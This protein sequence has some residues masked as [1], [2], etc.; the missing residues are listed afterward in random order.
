MYN[1]V[2]LSVVILLFV[3]YTCLISVFTILILE[4]P[5][6]VAGMLK[7][8]SEDRESDKQGMYFIKIIT[9]VIIM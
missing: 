1:M 9:Q 5:V 4:S 3:Y 8:V 2:V 7:T 6:S